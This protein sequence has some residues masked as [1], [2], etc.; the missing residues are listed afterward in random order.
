L[1]DRFG[2]EQKELL[3]RQLFH[4]RQ[5]SSVIEYVDKFAELVDQLTAYGHITEPVYYAMRFVDG[6]RDDI[7][8][9]VSLHRPATFDTAASLAMLQD[10]LEASFKTSKRYDSAY[11]NKSTPR[12]PQPLPPPPSR[13]DKQA[14][15]ILQEEKKICEGKTVEEKMA[16]LR[17]F[18]R[19]KYLCVC[20]AEKWSRDHKCSPAVQ[21]HAVQEEA[22]AGTE[23]PRTMKIQG[24]IQGKSVLILVDSGSTNTFLSSKLASQ[25]SGVQP[26]PKP[27]HVQVGN[28]GILTCASFIQQAHWSVGEYEFITDMKILPL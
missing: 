21:L 25:L 1:L 2:R 10:D 4:I 28:G 26:L 19:A 12:G 18:R 15:P 7:R 5:T 17:A 8:A 16:A 6:L 27:V 14:T 23:G 3:I 13:V 11:M 9:A 22:L 20:C 24:A